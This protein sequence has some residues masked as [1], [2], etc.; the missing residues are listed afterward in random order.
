MDR[1]GFRPCLV[2][3]T[4]VIL[5]RSAFA[6]EFAPSLADAR[7]SGDPDLPVVVTFSAPWCGWCRKMA[8]TTFPDPKIDEVADRFLWIKLD[9]DEAPG[10]AARL[11]V[12]GL[13]H[14]VVLNSKDQILG[15]QP[16][17]MTAGALIQ[18]LNESLAN[19]QPLDVVP[20]PLL[21]QLA[22]LELNDTP[23]KVVRDAVERMAGEQREQSIE[24]TDA[25]RSAGPQ[26]LPH[27]AT[28]LNDE[29]LAVRAAAAGLLMQLTRKELPFD[30]FADTETR[31][32]QAAAWTES[33]P[34]VAPRDESEELKDQPAAEEAA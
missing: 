8:T 27:L 7:K 33:F 20:Q 18:F 26:V 24:I 9:P 4:A 10:W 31:V 23:D 21:D 32:Q 17:Y 3:I 15:S 14:T 34:P 11:K 1:T 19:P 22:Q 2:L 25:L 30:P 28:M 16:G 13:P 5:G 6:I 12:H 29:R